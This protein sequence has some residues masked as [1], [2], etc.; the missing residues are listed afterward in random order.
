VPPQTRKRREQTDIAGSRASAARTVAVVL[1][2]DAK[3]PG[4]GAYLCRA[5]DGALPREQ[6]FEL[7]KKRRGIERTLRFAA[8]T[9]WAD[10][11]ES[12]S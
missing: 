7:A 10:L 5:Q 6:C 11:V 2:R 9:D 1:D 12:V 8:K 4:R 3:L